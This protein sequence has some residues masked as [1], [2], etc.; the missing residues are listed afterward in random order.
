MVSIV[1]KTL[2]TYQC[3]LIGNVRTLCQARNFSAQFWG[4]SSSL[5]SEIM[6]LRITGHETC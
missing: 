6:I 4:T 3:L 2:K 1:S 5:T